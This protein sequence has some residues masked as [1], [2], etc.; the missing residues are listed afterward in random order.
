M[1]KVLIVDDNRDKLCNI[2]SSCKEVLEVDESRIDTAA[3]IITA[4]RQLQEEFYDVAIVD[5]NL[6]TRFG[7]SP[8]PTNGIALIEY[9]KHSHTINKPT[10]IIAIT[11]YA[12]LI[13]DYNKKFYNDMIYL[14][15][16]DD[17]VDIWKKQI[18]SHLTYAR[19]TKLI[20]D[21]IDTYSYDIGIITALHDPELFYLL[22]LDAD[23][24]KRKRANDS[25]IYYEG[26]FSKGDKKLNVV[27]AASPQMGMPAATT[28]TLKLIE[29]Y[30]PRYIAMIGIAAGVRDKCELGDILVADMS[31]DYGNGKI[32]RQ[33]NGIRFEPDP[34]S[35]PL[36]ADLK[37]TFLN[38]I[39]ERQFLDAIQKEW[40]GCKIDHPLNIHIG[41]I[42]SGAAVLEDP[43]L[44][45][46]IMGHNRKLVGIEMEIYGVFYA[47]YHCTD[48]KPIP[49]AIKGVCDYG[50]K[51]K[52]NDYQTYAS[53]VSSKFL[54]NFALSEL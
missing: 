9:I 15:H 21:I 47:A 54:Y 43:E 29:H 25:T 51:N 24:Q 37:E 4:K 46:E 35:L 38:V 40:T 26:T 45:K 18:A 22:K 48:P 39:R 50:D 2:L 14:L 11:E 13:D 34:K 12:E 33:R 23:W 8:K 31:W 52:N 41:P 44:I 6:P 27:A 3:D 53:Y 36:S 17:S 5:L 19:E 20:P 32:K 1:F 42:A 16:Y 30:R 7:E 49:F 10:Y 28:V